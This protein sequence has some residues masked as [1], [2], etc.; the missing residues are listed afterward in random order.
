VALDRKERKHREMG[1]L[2]F[3]WAET[4]DEKLALLDTFFTQ[5]ANQ[6]AAMG[7]RDIFDA[8]ARAFYRDVALLEG[9]TP[10]RLKLGYVKL[11]D[12][13]L[14]TFSG[15]VCHNR[16]GIALSSLI[17]G[18]LQRQSPG[19]LLM[20]HQMDEAYKQGL[21][22]YDFGVGRARHK[23]EWCD[24]TQNLF[25]CFIAFKPQGLLV[26]QPLAVASR[27]KRAIKS[28]RYLWPL[29]QRL[30]QQLFGRATTKPA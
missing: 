24:V 14:A 30:R 11:G 17:E 16:L 4:R 8:H 20:R 2:V 23:D 10:S 19:M 15:T 7:I 27:L 12:E 1:D 29:A 22:F 18:D 6:F 28:N 26:T 13:V 3:G 5:K 25:D 9:D 21:A